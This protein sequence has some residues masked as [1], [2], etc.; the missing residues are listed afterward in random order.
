ML[1][2]WHILWPWRWRWYIPPKHQ[3]TSTELYG[4][5]IQKSVHFIVTSVR[6]SDPTKIILIHTAY[7]NV[8][9]YMSW[10]HGSPAWSQ[11]VWCGVMVFIKEFE[12]LIYWLYHGKFKAK[13]EIR[14][15]WKVQLPECN[16]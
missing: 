11:V 5:T 6:T 1:L 9:F 2:A 8:W 12:K 3:L 10:A 16:V 13:S 14:W 7:A 4:I 15:P